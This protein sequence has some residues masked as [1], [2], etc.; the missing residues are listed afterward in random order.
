MAQ[1]TWVNDIPTDAIS[2]MLLSLGLVDLTVDT[3]GVVL[4]ICKS[5]KR[6]KH[7][8]EARRLEYVWRLH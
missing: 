5:L 3:C 6:Q 8:R 1:S 4:Y 2:T 7:G